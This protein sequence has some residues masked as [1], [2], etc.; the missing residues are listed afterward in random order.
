M[1][2]LSREP[3]TW[4]VPVMVLGRLAIDPMTVMITIAE[5]VSTL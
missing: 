3:C 5:A 2:R 1:N 4:A